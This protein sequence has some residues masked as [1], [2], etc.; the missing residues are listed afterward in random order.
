[1]DVWDKRDE[2]ALKINE[3]QSSNA[4]TLADEQGLYPDWIEIVNTGT[5]TIDLSGYGLSDDVNKPMEWTFPAMSIG[6][7]E[8][9]VVFADGLNNLEAEIPHANFL[10]LLGRGDALPL[11]R[12]GLPPGPRDR[13]GAGD[14]HLLRPLSGRYGDFVVEQT[15]TPNMENTV[16]EPDDALQPFFSGAQS[17]RLHL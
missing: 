8:R 9:V 11:R 2:S 17:G 3:V 5:E 7:G 6:P 14:G 15:P 12:G 10:H 13:A 4:T 16:G 1:M